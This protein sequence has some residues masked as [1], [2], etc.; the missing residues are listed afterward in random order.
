MFG[1]MTLGKKIT[2][3]FLSAL[4]LVAIVGWLSLKVTNRLVESG[5]WVSHTH[6]VIAR[7]E[8]L[9]SHIKDVETGGRGYV[10]SGDDRHVL[11]IERGKAALPPV[12][13]EIRRLTAD[14]PNQQRRLDELAP[15]VARKVE[16]QEQLVQTRRE[17]GIEGI[18]KAAT[19]V[20][21]SAGIM[22]RVRAIVGE[23][24]REEQTLLKARE[25]TDA[26]AVASGQANIVYA[27]ILAVLLGGAVAYL[28]A[29]NIRL[30]VE[31]LMR[32]ISRVAEGALD[33]TIEA[34]SDDEI[35][36]LTKSFNAMT[37]KL[38]TT[39]VSAETE[40]AARSR[41]QALLD[42]IKES[43]PRL[44]SAA[45]ELSA[46]TAQQGSGAQQQAAAVAETV[47]TVEEVV[48]TAS[49]AAERIR[50]ISETYQRSAD[51]GRTGRDLTDATI[52]KVGEL[53][54]QVE[55]IA[56]NILALAEQAQAI[57]E[58]IA[59]V[60]DIAEQTNL[61]ALNAAIE[62]SRAGEHG[63]GFAVVATEVKALA[64][65]A[66]KA[67][68]QVRQILGDVQK[69]TGDAVM[70]TEGGTRN[71]NAALKSATQAGEVIKALAAT[72]TEAAQAASQIAASSNQQATGMTQ[73]HDAI[74][75][76]SVVTNQNLASTQQIE[77][78]TRDLDGLSARLKEMVA[79][80]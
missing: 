61:L 34:P 78:A 17:H 18:A 13:G 58:I 26:E 37:R 47:T 2:G 30:A 20:S 27:T 69:Q 35:G 63:R 55:S 41:I 21:A 7:V 62:A 50:S 29:R 33:V 1:R 73:I 80:A 22:D 39:T 77:R 25:A 16:V 11:Q 15:L 76:I 36:D 3:G 57:G 60:N 66:K 49:Q 24:E 43:T 12:I 31:R 79:G 54:T 5:R 70:A 38:Q 23:M 45:A 68:H 6:E 67:T 40:A 48:E 64:E 71:A 8:D 28:L 72:I 10:I 19:M 4:A 53:Q 51:I 14:N 9:L 75:D 74:K 46:A 42:L 59:T 44:A 65:Q 32:G 56:Q 52:G